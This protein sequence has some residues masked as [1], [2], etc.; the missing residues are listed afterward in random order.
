PPSR[1]I[2]PVNVDSAA[3]ASNW[4]TP[5]NSDRNFLNAGATP[6]YRGDLVGGATGRIAGPQPL[7][8]GRIACLGGRVR[9]MG[10][11]A[12]YM[13]H[14]RHPRACHRG[15]RVRGSYRRIALADHDLFRLSAGSSFARPYQPLAGLG[16]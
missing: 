8:V 9:P 12:P 1:G 13:A 3:L 4:P 16:R 2:A 6:N 14:P 15:A 7:A 11:A 5:S 10:M